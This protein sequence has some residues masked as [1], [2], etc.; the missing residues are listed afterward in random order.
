MKNITFLLVIFVFVSLTGCETNITNIMPHFETTEDMAIK[1][2]DAED[3]LTASTKNEENL[4]DIDNITGTNSENIFLNYYYIDSNTANYSLIKSSTEHL[5]EDTIALFDE[6]FHLKIIDIWYDGNKICVDLD[7]SRIGELDAFLADFSI[8]IDTTDMVIKT[9]SSYPNVEEIEIF[10]D[11]K[12]GCFGNQAVYKA[13]KLKDYRVEWET[14]DVNFYSVVDDLYSD[15]AEWEYKTERISYASL[16]DDTKKYMKLHNNIK[17][18]NIWY[19]NTR[20]FVDIDTNEAM[21][22]DAGTHAAIVGITKLV[23]TFSSYPGVEEIEFLMGGERKAMGEH[24]N[25]DLV[26]VVPGTDN[27]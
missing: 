6:C 9:L 14:A 15:D 1:N 8:E 13:F 7:S 4:L 3:G 22:L 19:E 10:I 16:L 11:G 5:L 18:I 25:F 26:F 12:R 17:V 2:T 27:L 20:L 24:Y 21:R 23:K